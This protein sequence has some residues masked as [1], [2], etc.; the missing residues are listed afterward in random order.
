MYLIV[1]SNWCGMPTAGIWAQLYSLAMTS[2]PYFRE[3]KHVF[4]DKSFLVHPFCYVVC[5]AAKQA[6]KQPRRRINPARPA[7]MTML[8]KE[9][10]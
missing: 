9:S 4:L 6:V 2:K 1:K 7:E 3:Q 8:R 5:S 10:M